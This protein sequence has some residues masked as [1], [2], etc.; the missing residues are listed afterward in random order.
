MSEKYTPLTAE[1]L[2]KQTKKL[3]FAT[4]MAQ[5]AFRKK[6]NVL[7]HA[8]TFMLKR[9]MTPKPQDDFMRDEICDADIGFSV[10][11][12]EAYQKSGPNR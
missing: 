3:A 12:L 4:G 5:R 10:E 2:Q 9:A 7:D 6:K 11:E 1:E 8:A